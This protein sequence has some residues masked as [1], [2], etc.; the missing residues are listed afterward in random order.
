MTVQVFI[1]HLVCAQ[2][3]SLPDVHWLRGGGGGEK[4]V[5]GAWDIQKVGKGQFHFRISNITAKFRNI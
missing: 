1:K 4:G 2:Y 3:Y 5:Q